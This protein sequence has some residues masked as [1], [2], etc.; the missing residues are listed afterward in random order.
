MK[1]IIKKIIVFTLLITC[2]ILSLVGCTSAVKIEN[3]DNLLNELKSSKLNV[4]AAGVISQT[5][6]SIEGKIIKVSNEDIQVFEYPDKSKADTDINLISPKGDVIGS[7]N[8]T[9]ASVPHF[10]KTDKMLILYVGKNEEIIK[11]L[12]KMLGRQF[13]G[14]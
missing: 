9:W 14:R 6:F 12:N 8:I 4:E 1:K 7:N 13:A 11:L 2:M 5:Y 3:Y 10:Y